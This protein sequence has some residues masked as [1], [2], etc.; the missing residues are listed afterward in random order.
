MPCI[1][2]VNTMFTVTLSE[3]QLNRRGVRR[4]LAGRAFHLGTREADAGD[5]YE[6]ILFYMAEY[7][8]SKGYIARE[9]YSLR[10]GI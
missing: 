8:T 6:V 10:G 5:E 4:S 7:Q 2:E 3:I 9:L 1:S